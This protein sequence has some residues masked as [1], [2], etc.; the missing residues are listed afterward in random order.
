MGVK[1]SML[2]L[3]IGIQPFYY[4][5]TIPYHTS[6]KSYTI[7]N[8]PILQLDIYYDNYQFVHMVVAKVKWVIKT[9]ESI[10]IYLYN[11]MKS[12]NKIKI[13]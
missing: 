9:N 8:V 10:I 12:F 5:Y 1:G 2:D 3:S 7:L 13:F 6:C 4:T 11:Y